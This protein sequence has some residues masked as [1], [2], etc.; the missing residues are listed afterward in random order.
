MDS[1]NKTQIYQQ[2]SN[3]QWNR[4]S[5]RYREKNNDIRSKTKGKDVV[6]QYPTKVEMGRIQ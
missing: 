6:L 4:L 3:E 5:L 1:Q 2:K